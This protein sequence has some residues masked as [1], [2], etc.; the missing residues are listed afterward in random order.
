MK[1]AQMTKDLTTTTEA[2]NI[3]QAARDEVASQYKRLKF[4]KGNYWLGNE[5]IGLGTEYLAQPVGW[6]KEWI[7]FHDN[8]IVE[9]H[10]YRVALK[11]K[12]PERHELDEYEDK[13]GWELGL[14]G[15]PQDPWTLQ[16]LLPLENQETGELVMFITPS[17]GGRRAVATL[18]DTWANQR[19]GPPIISLQCGTMPTKYG[20]TPCPNLKIVGWDEPPKEVKETKFDGPKSGP[21][22]DMNDEIPF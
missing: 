4:K 5:N 12:C 16:Y 15:E 7:K 10:V 2:E 21:Q 20:D 14:K 19:K 13:S 3:R 6:C 8:K 22:T 9:R 11:E 17:I 18:C 1:D